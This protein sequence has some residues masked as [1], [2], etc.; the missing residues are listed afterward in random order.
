MYQHAEGTQTRMFSSLL[1][2]MLPLLFQKYGWMDHRLYLE[3]FSFFEVCS[4]VWLGNKYVLHSQ[5]VKVLH[6]TGSKST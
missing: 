3:Q 2:E 5:R 1:S 6:M 4:I